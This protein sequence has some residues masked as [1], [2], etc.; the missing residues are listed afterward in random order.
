MAQMFDRVYRRLNPE[1]SEKQLQHPAIVIRFNFCTIA[2][3]LWNEMYSFKASGGCQPTDDNYVAIS[4]SLHLLRADCACITGWWLDAV[5][6]S[7]HACA[8]APDD[9]RRGGVDAGSRPVPYAAAFF[10]DDQI[11][12][13]V[14]VV[15]DDRAADDVFA[16][17]GV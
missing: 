3:F 13:P 17:S 5:C 2:P 10:C 6:G 14:R 12:R 16:D 4:S 11:A 15:D 1:K 9:E 8:D 7:A